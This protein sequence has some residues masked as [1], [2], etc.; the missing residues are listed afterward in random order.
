MNT[1][2]RRVQLLLADT[3]FRAALARQDERSAVRIA[4]PVLDAARDPDPLV[5]KTARGVLRGWLD[6]CEA[7]REAAVPRMP[8]EPV[9]IR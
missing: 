4:L 9:R 2:D 7:Q 1:A 3:D 5:R 6:T 8:V